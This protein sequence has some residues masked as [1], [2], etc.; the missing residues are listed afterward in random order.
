MLGTEFT[1][2]ALAIGAVIILIALFRIVQRRRSEKAQAQAQVPPKTVDSTPPVQETPVRPVTPAP[3]S[4]ILKEKVNLSDSSDPAGDGRPARSGHVDDIFSAMRP[5]RDRAASVPPVEPHQVPSVDTSDLVF[6]GATHSLAAMLPDSAGRRD[7]LRTELLGAG[8]YNPHAVINMAAIRYVAIIVPMLLMGVLLVLAPPQLELMA[9]AGIIVLPLVCWSLPRIYVQNRVSQRKAEIEQGLPDMLDM[10]NMC[11]SQGLTVPESLSRVGR[12][13]KPIYPA[14]SHELSIVAE[15]SQ[16]GTMEQALDN[17]SRRIDLPEISSFTSL[18][19]QTERMGTSISQ[20]LADYSDG[21]RTTLQQR[22]DE[23]GNRAAF[24]LL[25]PTVLCLMPAVYMVLLGPSIIA[26]SEF[27]S[28][29]G[30]GSRSQIQE[31][32]RNVQRR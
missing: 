26:M 22:A 16:V 5:A 8:F 13:L 18:L 17:L 25:F 28:G 4:S 9:V 30:P 11:V 15:Q 24:K 21:I 3:A 12:E 14:M 32:I 19:I 10:L 27:V 29:D 1:M 31:N 20:A 2:V 6:G 7:E 23:R